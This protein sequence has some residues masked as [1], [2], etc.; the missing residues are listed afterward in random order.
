MKLA[1]YWLYIEIYSDNNINDISEQQQIY[2]PN[3]HMCMCV[4]LC[5]CLCEF[6]F[7]YKKYFHWRL[8]YE[9]TELVTMSSTCDTEVMPLR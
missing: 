3:E 4:C 1:N 5:V 8:F 6:V 2:K 9:M 7:K